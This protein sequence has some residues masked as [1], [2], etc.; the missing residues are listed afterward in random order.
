MA[1]PGYCIA[2]AYVSRKLHSDKLKRMEEEKSKIDE[3]VKQQSGCFPSIFKKVHP[4]QTVLKHRAAGNEAQRLSQATASIDSLFGMRANG[5]FLINSALTSDPKSRYRAMAAIDTGLA[6]AYVMRKLH[7]E[8]MEKLEQ[9]GK[10]IV[11]GEK[12]G[13]NPTGCFFWGSK[14]N[15]PAKVDCEEKQAFRY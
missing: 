2:E 15:H 14:K 9:A 3:G 13:M 4:A 8:K 12:K 5:A 6:Q 7:Q 11:A 1:T 10:G